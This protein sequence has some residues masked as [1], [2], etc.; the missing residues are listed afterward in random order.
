[1]IIILIL[2]SL[3]CNNCVMIVCLLKM[4]WLIE[5]VAGII[6]NSLFCWLIWWNR[7][8]V[9]LVTKVTIT[10]CISLLFL[11]WSVISYWL[12]SLV[13]I[14]WDLVTIMYWT[15]RYTILLIL[16]SL[17]IFHQRII[18]GRV[19]SSIELL[20]VSQLLFFTWLHLI[21]AYMTSL[22]TRVLL[23]LWISLLLSLSCL[24]VTGLIWC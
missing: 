12:T 13:L 6:C 2:S 9:T 22:N 21:R 10:K 20:L 7:C 18:T 17:L 8:T 3:I 15:T 19:S 1:M 11:V 23:L 14:H 5:L 24:K 16:C 4:G